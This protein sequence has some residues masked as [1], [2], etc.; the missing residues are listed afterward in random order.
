MNRFISVIVPR[1]EAFDIS[2]VRIES[3]LFVCLFLAGGI[4]NIIIIIVGISK[5]STNE[6]NTCIYVYIYMY[7]TEKQQIIKYRHHHGHLVE[8]EWT[9]IYVIEND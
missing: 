5:S 2:F 8:I 4:I 6:N 3:G 9:G 1:L 7:H